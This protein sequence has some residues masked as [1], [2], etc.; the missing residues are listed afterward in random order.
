MRTTL[1]FTVFSAAMLAVVVGV[2]SIRTWSLSAAEEG[3]ESA[4]KHT[5]KEVMKIAHGKESGLLQKV[6]KGEASED[7]KKELLDVYIS[8]VE[9]KPSKGDLDSWHTLAGGAALAAAKVVVGREGALK[10]LESATNCKAC[11]SVHKGE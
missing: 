4:A 2:G 5:I 6:L 3:D 8:M 9:G 7:Q 1:R 10:E 11:H